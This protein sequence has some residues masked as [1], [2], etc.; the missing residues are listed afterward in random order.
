VAGD[1]IDGGDWVTWLRQYRSA[2]DEAPQVWG[3]HDYY[4]TTYFRTT[5]LRT[6]LDTVRGDV[7][8][9]ETGGIVE[10]RTRAGQVSLPAD[11]RRARAS[12]SLAL[13]TARAY[14]G[15]VRRAYLYQWQAGPDDRFDAGLLRPDGSERPALAAVRAQAGGFAVAP[16]VAGQAGAA[17]TAP[18]GGS[19]AVPR[20]VRVDRDGRLDVR[21]RCASAAPCRGRLWV[22]GAGWATGTLINGKVPGTVLRPRRRSFVVASGATR[23]VRFRVARSVIQPAYKARAMGLRLMVAS[24]SEPF[25]LHARYRVEAVR[26]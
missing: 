3:L 16:A 13:E 11:E 23:H 7:W 21:V 25:A 26:R 19:H 18:T 2:L 20:R 10:L 1:V 8:L 4:D 22:E 24:A 17:P 14:A 15:R 9:T 12:V 5:G 6:L